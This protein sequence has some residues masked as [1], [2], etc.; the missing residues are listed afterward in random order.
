MKSMIVE[1]QF[2]LGF[3]LKAKKMG[4]KYYSIVRQSELMNNMKNEC[5]NIDNDY[6]KYKRKI[7]KLVQTHDTSQLINQLFWKPHLVLSIIYQHG[8]EYHPLLYLICKQFAS[9]DPKFVSFFVNCLFH[10]NNA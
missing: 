7:I 9:I 5:Y 8:S 3:L 10:L 2:L 6:I 1:A 4:H